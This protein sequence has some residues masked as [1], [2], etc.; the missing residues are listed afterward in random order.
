MLTKQE[1]MWSSNFGVEYNK[2]NDWDYKE[3]N[4]VY[5]KYYGVERSIMNT[6]FL[7]SLPRDI[8]ILEVGSNY[9]IILKSL[10]EMGFTNLYGVEL[11][12]DG[13][14]TVKQRF[15]KYQ[16]LQ[17]SGLDLPFKNGYFDLVYTSG[18]LIHINPENL[19]KF[20]SEMVRCSKKY[21]WGF[22]YYADKVT[23]IP[24]HNNANLMWKAPYKQIFMDG[25]KE[26]KSVKEKIY[27]YI[28]GEDM[29]YLLEK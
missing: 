6:E 3:L 14:L 12:W 18:V 4:E 26:L 19:P 24:Y 23:E 11:Q 25:H 29:M 17:A 1:Q 21:I 13:V 9:G 10:E 22:E 5:K 7:D 8:R 27:P 16:V 15:P 20:M 2:R 28:K